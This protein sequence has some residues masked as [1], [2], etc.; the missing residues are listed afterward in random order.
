V[1]KAA[2]SLGELKGLAQKVGQTLSMVLDELPE[3]ARGHLSKLL[4]QS[5]ARPFAEIKAVIDKELG[6]D[7]FASIDETA[8]AAAS[9]GQVHRGRLHT[10]EDVAIKVQYPGILD[11]M[12]GDLKKLSGF[13]A[14]AGKLAEGAHEMF[15]E[16]RSTLMSELDY[17]L[18]AATLQRFSACL[19]GE[20]RVPKLYPKQSSKRVL[21]TE[22]VVGETLLQVEK[23]RERVAAQ[24]IRAIYGPALE[25]G[26]LH[27]DTHPGNFI[28][29]GE[30]LYVLDF[31]CV[32]KLSAEY[33]ALLRLLILT[34]EDPAAAFAKAGYRFP[35]GEAGVMMQRVIADAL[36][37]VPG[38]MKGIGDMK[39]KYPFA[40]AKG[41]M[42]A[43]AVIVSRS[44]I[45]GMNA[46]L[47]R[48]EM[49]VDV[50]EILRAEAARAMH[51]SA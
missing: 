34:D 20:L 41:R 26:L 1:A 27:G 43:E 48:L 47:R 9:L 30:N 35:E 8:L 32:R 21:T 10:G 29:S 3:D 51:K 14:I 39:K 13:T 23:S 44:L 12:E 15:A 36:R 16:L 40:M 46:T 24:V 2:E 11:A 22:L 42:P 45:V 19:S 28:V 17:E 6:A 5:Q 33:Q 25:H 18:E 50:R 38:A 31:G 37:G 4:G 49:K 7:A